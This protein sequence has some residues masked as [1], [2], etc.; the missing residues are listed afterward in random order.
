MLKELLAQF[1]F[2]KGN[3]LK[4]YIQNICQSLGNQHL[5][6]L[7]QD[8]HKLGKYL[9]ALT[10]QVMQSFC[11]RIPAALHTHTRTDTSAREPRAALA[12][13]VTA[14]QEPLHTCLVSCHFLKGGL[15]HQKMS[16]TDIRFI[17]LQEI[18]AY[19]NLKET[20]SGLC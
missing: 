9:P 10:P 6:E 7:L 11:H 8:K 13:M 4:I 16:F 17:F 1:K 3:T 2:V 12:T 14:E 5:L 20:K 15:F 19:W 18:K